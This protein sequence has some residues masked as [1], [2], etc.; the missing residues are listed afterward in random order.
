VTWR[1]GREAAEHT[2]YM[3]TDA[4]AVAEGL[5]PSVTSSTN[6]V[7][8][9]SLSLELGQ[10]YYW[11]VDE[12]NQAEAVSVWAG[13]VWAFSTVAALTV[14][15]FEGYN[16]ISPDRPFQTWLDGFGYSADEFFPVEYPGNGTGAGIGHDIW[17]LSS[18][19]YDGD[20]MET[21][22]TIAG[23]GQS[24][25]F[26]YTNTGGVASQTERTFAA[27][28]DWTV[29]G[30]QT[31]S[32]AFS[33]QAGNTG[34]LYAKINDTKITYGGD[35]ENLTVG[36]WQA[37]NIDL[38]VL[39]VQSVT[40][41][42]IGVDG[43]GAS[44]MIL[45]D[46][47]R[48][49]AQPGQVIIPVEPD[50][51]SLV[52]YYSFDGNAQ[53]ASGNNRH[54]T[55]VGAPLFVSG[56]AGQAMEFDGVDDYVNVDGYKGINAD[57]S[58]PNNPFQQPFTISNWVKTTSETGDTEMVTWG[59]QGA[60]TRLTWRIH[61]GRLRTEHNAGN[62]RGNTYVNDGEWHHIA[63]VVTEGA[64]LRPETTH[65][66]VDG[67]ED[68]YFSGGDTAFNLT[69]DSDVRIGMS[70]PHEAAAAA[71]VRYF[72]GALDEVR[73]YDRALS[74]AEIAGL[75]GKTNPIHLPF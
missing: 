34:T 30:V 62:L 35:P 49:H 74:A 15:D 53:D 31:L 12:V 44:G 21:T 27:P 17:S 18:P 42:Q 69:A 71:N 36:V 16:N 64:N 20:I 66:Y 40:T 9:G 3:S 59:L 57:H 61:E 51:A 23:S 29:G 32:I 67:F 26:Y 50:T 19:H 65:L 11:R 39:N 46:D 75:A 22:N 58:D 2:L 45:I 5:A 52:A 38:S 54:G 4:N 25:P 72:L 13:P 37:W 8:L 63:L 73:I 14:D 56:A 43:S 48:L 6:T 24:M 10:T 68:T 33:G 55:A 70:G 7:D 47:I 28:Q 60:G 41:L 1:A